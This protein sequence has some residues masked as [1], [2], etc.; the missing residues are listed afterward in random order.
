MSNYEIIPQQIGNGFLGKVYQIIS[1]ESPQNKLIIKIFDSK[2]REHYYQEKEFLSKFIGTEYIIN[3]KT[4]DIRLENSNVFVHNSTYL[5]F[6]YLQHGNLSQYLLYMENYPDISEEFVKLFCYKLLKAL[7]II[8]FN[9]ICHNKLDILNIMLDN[10]FNP[11]IIHFSEAYMVSNNNFRKDFEG[12]ANILAILMTQGKFLYCK[13]NKSKKYFEIT[14]NNKR[15]YEDSKFWILLNTKIPPKFIEFF[16]ALIKT[17]N[18]NIDDLFNHGW[19]SGLNDINFRNKIESKSKIY[20]QK[21]YQDL[22][23]L[24]KVESFIKVDFNSILNEPNNYN[25]S[26]FNDKFNKGESNNDEFIYNLK[27]KKIENEPKGVLFDYIEII[28]NNNYLDKN[29]NIPVNFMIQYQNIIESTFSDNIKIKYSDKYLS[30]TIS[31]EEN[32]NNEIIEDDDANKNN[33]GEESNDND[34]SIKDNNISNDEDEDEDLIINVELLEYNKENNIDDIYNDKYY[35]MFNY[36]QG[37]I[38]EYYLILKQLKDLAK[39]LLN[40][41]KND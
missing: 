9:N 2:D 3:L 23:E 41:R 4:C 38:Y 11:V 29:N 19:L 37:E 33:K 24:K 18:V 7:K 6:D 31:F 16:N 27:I 17:K 32:K 8:H 10:E 35:L 5:L 25:N 1:V 12:L 36:I 40:K 39:D 30:Y 15:Q 34:S 28:T 13:F 20:F 21:R 14:D 22:L 26:L